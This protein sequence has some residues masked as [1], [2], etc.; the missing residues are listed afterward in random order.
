M[1]TNARGFRS[2]TLTAWLLKLAFESIFIDAAQQATTITFALRYSQHESQLM[3]LKLHQW[4]ALISVALV[5]CTITKPA[6][7][8]TIQQAIGPSGLLDCGAHFPVNTTPSRTSG[9][10]FAAKM[11][12]KS[13]KIDGAFRK[14]SL[15]H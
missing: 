10:L 9:K 3:M 2:W 8:A 13:R 1:T 15:E 4:T 12:I 6:C 5:T 14:T 11:R 7:A